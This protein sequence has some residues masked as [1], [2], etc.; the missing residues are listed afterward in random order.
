MPVIRALFRLIQ[1]SL[2]VK[3]ALSIVLPLVAILGVFT[4]VEYVRH[5]EATLANLSFVAAQTA[6]VV[7]NSLQHE[8][9]SHNLQG[10]QY[11]LDGVGQDKKIRAI[12]LLNTEGRI[13]FAPEKQNL[14]EQLDNRD[15]T[16]Q[17]CHRLPVAE[18]PSSVVVTLP[19]GQRIFRSMDPLENRPECHQCHAADERLTGVLLT[20]IWVAPFETQLKSDLL[21][22]LGWWAGTIL[23]TVGVVNFV[24]G[25]LVI[26]RLE[27]VA[28]TLTRFGRGQR[29]LR[30]PDEG[31]DEIG[32][33]TAAFNEMG[34][35]LHAEETQTASLTRDL[36]HLASE[37]R[38]LL[39]RLITAQEE[40]RR[41]VARDLHDGLGQDLAGLAFGLEAVE[42][43]GGNPLE[44][45]R[46]HLRQLRAQI[47]ETTNRVYDMIFALRPSTLDDLGLAPALRAHAERALKDTGVKFELEASGLTRRLPPEIE[48]ALF[49]AFQEA[50]HNV[51]RHAQASHVRLSLAAPD[52]H[53]EGEIV[54]DGCGFDVDAIQ[55]N[56][57]SPRG[58]GLLGMQERVTQCGGTLVI[59]SRPGAGTRLSV[60]VPLPEAGND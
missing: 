28:R 34:L 8:M 53:F 51:A 16:C 57:H 24:T 18:R 2:R 27:Q 37:R 11:L 48:T 42:R 13:V 60:H 46:A 32:Q 49:R 25:R 20:D 12:Y 41:R 9:L 45:L 54:D 22:N 58:L 17:P 15:A 44:P 4:G 5:R 52:G 6:Q 19:D 31:P 30:L 21:E 1:S 59:Y 47:A 43:L 35:R 3:V 23:V 33:V 10:V 39:Q 14:G 26:R 29:D 36:R 7:E 38:D 50:L 40:E 55:P 56:E